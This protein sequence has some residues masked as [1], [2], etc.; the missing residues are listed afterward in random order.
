MSGVATEA[1]PLLAAAWSASP[2]TFHALKLA[3][4]VTG[5]VILLAL[6]RTPVAQTTMALATAVYGAVVAYHLVNV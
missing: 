4:V 1:N 6:R 2:F 3:L 5:A